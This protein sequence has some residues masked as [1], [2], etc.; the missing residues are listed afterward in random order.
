MVCQALRQHPS[1]AQIM[2]SGGTDAKDSLSKLANNVSTWW[3][4]L[5]PV[6]KPVP[7]SPSGHSTI[8]AHH[9]QARTACQ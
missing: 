4:N 5:D 6:P 8:P 7:T 2:Q 9:Q 1:L 3:A